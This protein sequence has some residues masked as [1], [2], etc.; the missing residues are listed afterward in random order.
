MKFRLKHEELNASKLIERLMG[1]YPDEAFSSLNL[2][3]V[4]VNPNKRELT[5][6]FDSKVSEDI[7]N[8][9]LNR[10]AK[11]AS[12][13]L[14]SR[15]SFIF[16]DEKENPI[17]DTER[18]SEIDKVQESHSPLNKAELFK[19]VNG[20][21]S[22]LEKATI[23][24]DGS[25]V[26]I[27][28]NSTFAR[29]RI[30]SKKRE[31]AE[32]LRKT[33]GKPVPF[34]II[35]N[36]K[37][38]PENSD[39]EAHQPEK[40]EDKK[41]TNKTQKAEKRKTAT[42]LMGRK[43]K[44]A[45][46]K[47]CDI[48]GN[49]N[50]VVIAGKVFGIDI[51]KG[52]ITV[53]TFKVTDFTDSLSCKIIGKKA[54]EVAGTLTDGE[55]VIVRGKLEYDSRKREE[56]MTVHDL[57]SFE[58]P[59]RL[60]KAEEKR[61]ELHLHTKMSAL[62]SVL[63]IKALFK[64]LKEWG[65]TAVALTDHGVVQSIPE[66]YFN[67]K[68][69]GIKPIFGMEGYM[70]N[71]LEAIVNNLGNYDGELS[72]QTYVVFDLETTGLNP[73]SDEIIEFGA[74]K[75][76][77]KETIDTFSSLVKP[78]KEI[79]SET[80]EITGINNE[81]LSEAPALKEVLTSFLKFSEGC[82]LVAHNATFDYR[83]VRS[84][85]KELF[86][87]DWEAPYI[88][89]LALSKSLL[90]SRSYSLDNVV[91]HLKLGNF[92]H[93]RASEDARVTA[94]VFKKFME[95]VNK[96]GIKKLSELEGLR[97]NINISSL[98]PQ[99]VSILAR[100]KKGLRNLYTLVTES[101]THYFH[102]K[103]RI[104]KSLLNKHREGLLIGSACVSGELSR[105]YLNGANNQELEE[106]AKFFD[107]IEIMPLDVIEE[108]D[109]QFSKDTLKT[110]YKEFYK[111]G[112]RL[113]IP[114]VMTGDVHF[115][116]PEHNIFRAAIQ[117]AQDQNNFD[118]Q[119]ALYLRTTEEMLRA[120]MEIFEDEKIAREVVITNTNRIANKIEQVIPVEGKLH[121]PI[122]DG[123]DEQVRE[124]TMKKAKEIYGEPLP[125]IVE[126]RLEKE[127]HAIIDH[128]YAVLYLIAQK[129][130][131]KSNDDGYVV[132]SRGSVGSSLVA[133]MMGITE[134][135]PLPPHYVCPDCK[136]SE[137]I[138]D[139]S[140]ESGY[141]L[142]DKTCQKCGAKMNKS[143]Q[144]I[145]FETFLGFEG[146]KVPDIDLNF[147][148]EYQE[149]AHAYLE[150]LFG[151]DHVYRAG[152]IS[153]VAER[154]AYGF[155]RAYMEKTGKRLRGAEMDRLAAGITGVKRTTGQH[156]G[157]LM[158]VPKDRDVHEFTPVQYPANDTRS[159]TRTTHFAY[160]VIHD[161]LVKIDALGHDDPTFIK[162]LKDITGIDPT[163]IPM[164]D[165]KTLSI[166]SSTKALGIKPED[167][168]TDV[169]TLGIPEFGTQFV[170]GMLQE[171]HPRSFGELVRISGL[172]HGTD[173]WLNNARDWIASRKATL[174]EVIACRDD[175]MNYLIQ[176]GIEP[177]K[178]FKIMEKVR[179]GKGIEVEEEQLMREKAVPEW[180]IESCKRIK[181]LFPKAHA[182]AYVSMAFRVAYYKVHYPL[183]FYSTYFTV[184]DGEFDVDLAL[185]DIHSIKKEIASL[186]G[187]PDKNVKERSK[188]TLLEVILEMKLR[189]FSFLPVD[190]EKSD[191][192]R[193]I[194]EEKALRIP[195]NRIKN[196]GEKAAISIIKERKKKPFSSVEDLIRRTALNKTTVEILRKYG[197]L[198]GLPEKEQI[199]L[200]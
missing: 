13:Q 184:K 173:V 96:R 5:V 177:L 85:I 89:T 99:H 190:L 145:P 102:G 148:G 68:K 158:I 159:R 147:S 129:M 55:G 146:D 132:G 15:I 188:E 92:N 69:E 4:V 11:I 40:N 135:N 115:L 181:Y 157:G 103:P 172:S 118:K 39:K 126:A 42:V 119:P 125:E 28:V 8:F 74:V 70:I 80:F 141:D 72:E 152:T 127:L 136:D 62:D 113:N 130:V 50:S 142:K 73:A 180:F 38:A 101:H 149:R 200:F 37:D 169:G 199:T 175:I 52:K 88:D 182:V 193:F 166:F 36:V 9:L 154:T 104:P 197:A 160:E 106:I 155:V 58:F 86:D 81:M 194:I 21:S 174:G 161:D 18:K 117:A 198:K 167:L 189:G 97:K 65:H 114:V 122:I 164:D 151:R 170:R 1:F 131:K 54:E 163:T 61:V 90:K 134:V 192:T 46:Q 95:M 23:E 51:W 77:G 112:R 100:N 138:L 43:I 178:A 6:I 25:K 78:K 20:L 76:K 140:V 16:L 49:E 29:Q 144:N 24:Y 143:G 57:N 2:S 156:P 41:N 168:G 47:I 120:A 30:I 3:S 107:Y 79:T 19:Y 33:L 195:F 67:A 56:V 109:R 187:N 162:Y 111:I 53:L 116:E 14:K 105:A 176:K 44:T 121:P 110:M 124:I 48:L 165:K 32:A 64:T 171:T 82:I 71:D 22:Y 91:K 153:T 128:G 196:L 34:E 59:K 185:G 26:M 83:F 87:E 27:I 93:H 186:K 60:D 137:F 63:E 75:L 139:G 10:F 183:A 7:K 35:L 12:N 84:A 98:K 179:K 108:N 123:A 94:E 150:K 17:K 31:L 45:P 191:A 66:F 133:T